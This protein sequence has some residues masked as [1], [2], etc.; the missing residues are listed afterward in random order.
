MFDVDLDSSS[1]SLRDAVSWSETKA[2]QK[3]VLAKS[4]HETTFLL[5]VT[6]SAWKKNH[7]ESDGEDCFRRLSDLQYLIDSNSLF[8][9]ESLG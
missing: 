4:V 5:V 3:R 9:F 7:K 8:M 2:H 1:V 6:Q